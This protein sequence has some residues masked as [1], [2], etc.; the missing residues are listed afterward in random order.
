MTVRLTTEGEIELTGRC[1][2]EDAEVLQHYLVAA[3]K[4]VVEWH[5]CEHL[6]SAVIQVLLVAS[7]RIRGEPS[8]AFLIAHIA[9]L[10]QRLP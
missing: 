6:H 2:A 7:P 4:S 1:G 9:P 3:S 8:N 5:G 10:L